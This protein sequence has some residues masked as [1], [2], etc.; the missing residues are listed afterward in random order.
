MPRKVVDLSARSRIIRDEPWHLHFWESTPE[1]AL[2][3]LTNPREELR[4]L[5]IELPRDC[6]IETV[7]TNHD[8]MTQATRGLTA[9]RDNGPIIICNIGGGNVAINFYRV[10]MYAHGEEDIGRFEK[11]LLHSEDEQSTHSG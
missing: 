9:E 6:R 10:T 4:N 3:Y 2:A 5:G 8:W 7:I 1:E 11:Q